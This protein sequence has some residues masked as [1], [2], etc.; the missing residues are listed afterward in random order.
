M[1]TAELVSRR[2]RWWQNGDVWQV[3]LKAALKAAGVTQRDVAEACGVSQAAVS[4]WLKGEYDPPLTALPILARLAG[5]RIDEMLGEGRREPRVAELEYLFSQLSEDG[6][7]SILAFL[8][9]ITS[10]AR[11]PEPESPPPSGVR[12]D[13]PKRKQP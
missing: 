2:K 6:Q 4:F 8:G 11:S 13:S 5:M 1:S 9:Q 7:A 10:E 3:K 12:Q